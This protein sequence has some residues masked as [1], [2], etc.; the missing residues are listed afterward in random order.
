MANYMIVS[1]PKKKNHNVVVIFIFA[2]PSSLIYVTRDGLLNEIYYTI[3][4]DA[5]CSLCLH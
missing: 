3:H 1:Q 2:A 5:H 4:L